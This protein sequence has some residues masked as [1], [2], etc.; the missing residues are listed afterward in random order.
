[1]GSGWLS[2]GSPL[3]D[4]RD[5]ALAGGGHLGREILVVE[6]GLQVEVGKPRAGSRVRVGGMDRRL[7]ETRLTTA[8][9]DLAVSAHEQLAAFALDESLEVGERHPARF[10][11]ER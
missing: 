5:A 8:N 3:P 1:L 10:V 11:F 2:G 9:H 7:T 4:L 6:R